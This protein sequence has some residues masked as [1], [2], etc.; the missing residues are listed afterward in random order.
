VCSPACRTTS[1]SCR[2]LVKTARIQGILVGSRGMPERLIEPVAS[3]TKP[4]IDKAFT[5]DQAIDAY[6]YLGSSAPLRQS[7]DPGE[8][9]GDRTI[10][11]CVIG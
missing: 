10:E 7:G 8:G 4:V 1:T 3:R 9:R 6:R 5:F 11:P 2:L